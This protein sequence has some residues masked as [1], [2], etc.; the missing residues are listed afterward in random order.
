MVFGV[1]KFWLCWTGIEKHIVANKLLCSQ[2]EII[3]SV[4]GKRENV[5]ISN[6]PQVGIELWASRFKIQHST[7]WAT[8]ISHF[9]SASSTG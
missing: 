6:S 1:W 4:T 8:E 5:E 9:C 2:L 7:K 3:N